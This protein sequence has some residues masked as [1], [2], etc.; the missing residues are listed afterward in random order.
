MS[1]SSRKSQIGAWGENAATQFLLGKG[2]VV[3]TK[4]YRVRGGELDIVAAQGTALVIV[5][6]KTRTT[7][8]YG[9]PE[10]GVTFFK[11]QRI[12]CATH[13]LLAQTEKRYEE[14]RFDIIAI[15]IDIC[16]KRSTLTHIKDFFTL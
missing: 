13:A 7:K 2:Y 16:N 4:N 6:V 5:V 10:D 1:G 12:V 11:R 14:I 8:Y 15:H 9:Y 3:I